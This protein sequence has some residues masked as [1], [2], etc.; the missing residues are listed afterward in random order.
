M[1]TQ[2]VYDP[3]NASASFMALSVALFATGVVGGA[4]VVLKNE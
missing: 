1:A 2:A 4:R 3:E